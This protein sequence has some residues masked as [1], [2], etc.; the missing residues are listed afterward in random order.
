MRLFIGFL[1]VRTVNRY[2]KISAKLSLG[3]SAVRVWP[4][5]AIKDKCAVNHYV[6]VFEIGD[7]DPKMTAAIS[8][9]N[10]TA[11]M[12][13]TIKLRWARPTTI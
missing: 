2:T 9:V 10:I 6:S 8:G 1:G 13:F 12:G 7:T 5:I 4:N 11:I 3:H